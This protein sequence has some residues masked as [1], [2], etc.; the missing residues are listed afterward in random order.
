[1]CILPHQQ[2]VHHNTAENVQ[3]ADEQAKELDTLKQQ[4]HNVVSSCDRVQAGT[5]SIA[6]NSAAQIAS[7]SFS[8][9]ELSNMLAAT[10]SAIGTAVVNDTP[11][12]R[13]FGSPVSG[14]DSSGDVATGVDATSRM[15]EG[16]NESLDDLEVLQEELKEAVSDRQNLQ[17]MYDEVRCAV[18]SVCSYSLFNVVCYSFF[19]FL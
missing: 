11:P 12:A 10:G 17:S 19:G 15:Q 16:N 1:M 7:Q 6:D 2:R 5:S 4:L 18:C 13:L 14:T 8:L 9:P 3:A